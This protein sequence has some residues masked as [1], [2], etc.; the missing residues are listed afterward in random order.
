MHPL[1]FEK[2]YSANLY[3][4]VNFQTY[5][6]NLCLLKIGSNR[7]SYS[8]VFKKSSSADHCVSI[9]FQSDSFLLACN[10]ESLEEDTLNII[11]SLYWHTS[12]GRNGSSVCIECGTVN[13]IYLI[14]KQIL[15]CLTL[16]FRQARMLPWAVFWFVMVLSSDDWRRWETWGK[17]RIYCYS[18]FYI[19]F[20]WVFSKIFIKK[21]GTKQFN[22]G[23][24]LSLTGEP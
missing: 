12:F 9:L 16:A 10:S 14:A 3:W 11:L 24:M 21:S 22:V 19:K 8:K 5:P 18:C 23:S 13:L 4:I 7:L 15:V 6:R 2:A 20:E 17:E 1:S